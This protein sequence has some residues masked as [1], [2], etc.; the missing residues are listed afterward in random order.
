MKAIV[1]GAGIGGLTAALCLD[2]I[3]WQVEVLERAPALAEVGAGVQISPNGTRI[4]E[5][6]GVMPALENQLF[7]PEAIE[8]RAGASGRRIFSLRMKGYAQSRWGAR[9][10]QIHRADLQAALA[11]TLA[12]ARDALANTR[13]SAA[14]LDLQLP[15]G[16]RSKSVV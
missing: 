7:E 16:T 1:V 3:G 11:A 8:L 13:Y 14:L 4:L 6:L 5:E 12:E 15:D 10:F 2:R 9:F